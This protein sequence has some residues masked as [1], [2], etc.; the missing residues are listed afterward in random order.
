[1]FS[2]AISFCTGC[3]KLTVHPFP[4]APPIRFLLLLYRDQTVFC[5]HITCCSCLSTLRW[6]LVKLVSLYHFWSWVQHEVNYF[7]EWNKL[8][9]SHPLRSMK[10]HW[11][12]FKRR[13]FSLYFDPHYVICRFWYHDV[14]CTVLG[15]QCSPGRPV[16]R[17]GRFFNGGWS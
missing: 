5:A 10:P 2:N 9:Q 8:L 15:R 12:H 13:Q 17:Y 1:M 4:P 7:G 14:I 16:P 3:S 6:T 11:Q